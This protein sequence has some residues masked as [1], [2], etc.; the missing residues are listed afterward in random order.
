MLSTYYKL[1]RSRLAKIMYIRIFVY[2]SNCQGKRKI[3]LVNSGGS[4]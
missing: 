4:S 3:V 1:R 2:N